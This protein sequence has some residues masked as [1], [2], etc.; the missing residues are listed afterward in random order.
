M[1][2]KTFLLLASCMIIVSLSFILFLHQPITFL[3]LINNIFLVSLT[4]TITGASLVVVQGG[5]FNGITYSFKRFFARVTK[6]G[7]YA[8]ELDG[9]LEFVHAPSCNFTYPLLL[10]GI[11]GCSTTAILSIVFYL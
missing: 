1:K 11:I 4:S 6:N 10:A 5:L 2:K 8:F 9:D 7:V 3:T